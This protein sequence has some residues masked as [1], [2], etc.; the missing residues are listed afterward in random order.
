MTKISKKTAYPLK[1]PV[2]DDYFVGSDSENFGKTVNFDFG[3]ATKVMNALNGISP[4]GYT[5]KTSGNILLD[6]LTEA[7]FYS[8]GN[9]TTVADV[10]KFYINKF[11]KNAVNLANLYN[12]LLVNSV[13]FLFKLR[14]TDPNVYVYFNLTSIENHSDYY[15][16][17]VTLYKGNAV[18]PEL[19]AFGT[20]FFD[21]ELKGSASGVA[22]SRDAFVLMQDFTL[23]N[24]VLNINAGWIWKLSGTNYSNGADVSFTIP[25][26]STGRS[27]IDYIIPN[28]T[29]GFSRVSGVQTLGFPIAPQIPANGLYVTFFIVSDASVGIP[30][31]PNVDNTPDLQKVTDIG[32]AITNTIWFYNTSNTKCLGLTSEQIL[33]QKT[34]SV[35]NFL[36]ADNTTE[37]Y[38][39]QFPNKLGGSTQTLAMVSDLDLKVDKVAGKG[40][41]TEDYT[42]AEK[43]KLADTYTKGEVNTKVTGVYKLKGSVANYAAL[44]SSGQIIG[45]V[46]N[47]VDT[48]ANYVWTGNVWDELGATVDISGKE[49]ALT[50]STPLSRSVNTISMPQAT[51]SVS[52]YL[53]ST[54][55]TTFTNKENS[56]NKQNSLVV[57]GTGTKFPTVDAVNTGISGAVS[58]VVNLT[59]NQSINGQK[60]FINNDTTLG[61]IK[62]GANKTTG[63][64]T[65]GDGA[66]IFITGTGGNYGIL[67]DGTFSAGIRNISS[68]SSFGIFS[69]PTTSNSYGFYSQNTSTGVGIYSRNEV[70]GVGMRLE[71][72]S[73]A[74]GKPFQY[75]KAGT[76]KFNILDNGT[77]NY[78]TDLSSSYTDRTLVDKGYVNNRLVVETAS[79]YSLTNADS[80]GIV[81]FTA[82][83]TLTI[84]TGLADGFECTF[85]TLAGV[86]LT[87]VS[88]GNTLNNATGTT[89]LPQLSFTLK[90]M[91]AAN[92]YIVAGSL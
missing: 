6:V 30:Q 84:P 74:T 48:G 88:T 63:G 25:Y 60:S 82:S 70:G 36:R 3:D 52:G 4:I 59:G 35:F 91:L 2:R 24:P 5:F 90:R 83:T 92:T 11:D 49:N 53:S 55:F 86:T 54:D 19:T 73:A 46:W 33:F 50:F 51:T 28:N 80:G 57:D 8:L 14:G 38:T 29:N 77:A 43:A 27:R 56:A 17:N 40:L 58:N 62:V 45:D 85:V 64:S 37:S 41:S 23:E 7:E 32:Y 10:T 34:E 31:E 16:F 26:C 22:D 42:T 75:L 1:K 12:Y 78:T 39:T 61:G 79:P 89:M 71:N 67:I 47:L 68:G 76:E 21:F 9:E 66:G 65:Y 81:I 72:L 18:L 20:Y 87:V 15:L 13:D 69:S 44:P